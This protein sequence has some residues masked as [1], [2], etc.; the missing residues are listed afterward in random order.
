MGTFLVQR[1]DLRLKKTGESSQT[2][3]PISSPDNR[4][5][6]PQPFLNI[7]TKKGRQPVTATA[8]VE[9]FLISPG[10]VRGVQPL[11]LP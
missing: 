11:N 7:F 10:S 9:V 5:G 2:D 3:A 4:I 8:P 6:I 1:F